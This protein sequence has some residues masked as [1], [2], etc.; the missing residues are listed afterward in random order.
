[1]STAAHS[2]V[3]STVPVEEIRSCFPALD[4]RQGNNPVAYFDG[5]GG[6]QVPGRWW[7]R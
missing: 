2:I 3:T 6:T 4:R 7:K 1:M 5:P